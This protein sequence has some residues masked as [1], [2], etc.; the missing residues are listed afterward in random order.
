M[1]WVA[2]LA[3]L[4]GFGIA[5]IALLD[6]S[7]VSLPEATDIYVVTMTTAHPDRWFYY[8]AMATIGSV[9]GCLVLY[10]LARKGGEAFLRKRFHQRSIDRA[11]AAFRKYG[12]LTVAVPSILP[13]P[14]P[15]KIFVILAGAA[16]VTPGTFALAVMGGRAFRYL[17]EALLARWYGEAARQFIDHNLAR[18]SIGLA[19][20]VLFVGVA[21]VYWRRRRA[22]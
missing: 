15:F 3:A 8:G 14:T 13:P 2:P 17:S 9:A 16:D 22:V 20:L 6:S 1:R 4:G 10:Y 21:T 12:L 19:A 7:F 11:F 5:L 18:V